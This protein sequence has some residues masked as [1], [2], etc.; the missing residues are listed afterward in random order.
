MKATFLS[1]P[2]NNF[3]ES[4][5]FNGL[6]TIQIKKSSVLSVVVFGAPSGFAPGRPHEFALLPS[7]HT[8]PRL[9]RRSS[10]PSSTILAVVLDLRKKMSSLQSPAQDRAPPRQK[11]ASSL[12]LMALSL[13]LDDRSPE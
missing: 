5:L 11:V 3:F 6:R 7:I 13:A 8:D 4:G 1:F 10:S 12:A 2:F 9:D